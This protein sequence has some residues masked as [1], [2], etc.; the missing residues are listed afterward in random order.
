MT[1]KQWWIAARL[2]MSELFLLTRRCGTLT[3][4]K[5][6]ARSHSESRARLRRD[7]L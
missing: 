7:S 5:A 1:E 4:F 3:W 6:K 2:T